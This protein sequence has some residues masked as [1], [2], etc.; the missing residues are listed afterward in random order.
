MYY[1][2]SEDRYKRDTTD[3]LHTALLDQPQHVY[4]RPY[5]YPGGISFVITGIRSTAFTLSSYI[6]GLNSSKTH[7]CNSTRLVRSLQ[8]EAEQCEEYSDVTIVLNICCQ[9]INVRIRLVSY[10]YSLFC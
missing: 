7:V 4:D 1:L 5:Q 6:L 8:N 3:P 9:S 10:R 2:Q